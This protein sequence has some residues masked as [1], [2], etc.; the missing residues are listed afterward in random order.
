MRIPQNVILIWA[1]ANSSIPS[2]WS[3]ETALDDKFPKGWGAENPNTTGGNP[4]HNHQANDPGH[5]LV[6]HTH[7][8]TTNAFCSTNQYPTGNWTANC[9][10][11]T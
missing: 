11:I 9:Q 10:T 1:G 6:N 8:F 7:T 2:G 3:R 4:T 5:S